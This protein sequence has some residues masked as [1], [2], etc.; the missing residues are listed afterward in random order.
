MC[1]GIPM[2]VIETGRGRA[3]CRDGNSQSWVDTRLVDG[4]GTGTW[5]LVFA[6]AAGR[7]SAASGLRRWQPLYRHCRPVPR[8]IRMPLMHCLRIWL[9]GSRRSLPIYSRKWK[10]IRTTY[11]DSSP[12][13][14]AGD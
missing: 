8:A 10:R 7:L 13:R 11:D 12:D 1:I 3:L 14:P 6:G 5:L 4:A 9:T 2:Q